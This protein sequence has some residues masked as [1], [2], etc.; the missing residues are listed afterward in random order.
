MLTAADSPEPEDA[1]HDII[2][3]LLLGDALVP[4]FPRAY[5][6]SAARNM[7]RDQAAKSRRYVPWI[8]GIDVR[9]T[10]EPDVV[11]P[12]LSFLNLRP[13]ELRW[14]L[15]YYDM[16]WHSRKARWKATRLRR[17]ARAL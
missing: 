14:L 5:W 8:D 4:E 9:D 2:V 13:A 1:A 3:R 15:A 6:W 10:S 12:D 16:K 17:K 11:A 7:V